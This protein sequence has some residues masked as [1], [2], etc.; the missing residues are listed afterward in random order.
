MDFVSCFVNSFVNLWKLQGVWGRGLFVASCLLI[1]QLLLHKAAYEIH[2]LHRY[3]VFW[4]ADLAFDQGTGKLQLRTEGVRFI[5]ISSNDVIQ[6]VRVAPT[7]IPGVLQLDA[8]QRRVLA[9]REPELRAT[10][11]EALRERAVLSPR[12]R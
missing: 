11:I 3:N 10:A 9:D 8:D 4:Q 5:K 7:G 6:P 2:S 12:R 1:S